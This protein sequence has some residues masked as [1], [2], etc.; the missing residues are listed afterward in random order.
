M[1]KDLHAGNSVDREGIGI[2]VDVGLEEAHVVEEHG[3]VHGILTEIVGNCVGSGSLEEVE[4]PWGRNLAS[5]VIV[6]KQA[7]CD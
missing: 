5:Q 7:A 2:P 4:S 1:L 6:S 3:A